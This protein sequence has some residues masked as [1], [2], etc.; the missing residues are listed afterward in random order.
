MWD[1]YLTNYDD[2]GNVRINAKKTTFGTAAAVNEH[3][4]YSENTVLDEGNESGTVVIMFN[5][6][7]DK[8][9]TWFDNITEYDESA[10]DG[11]LQLVSHDQYK[12]VLNDNL[13]FEKDTADHNGNT[14]ATLS[15]PFNQ[16]NFRTNGRY[17]VRSYARLT[18][19]QERS[20]TRSFRYR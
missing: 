15:I 9:K 13:Q 17:Y 18:A 2:E 1:Y 14:V 6:T 3:P 11:A 7:A 12:T 5:Y 16:S 8:D 19:R 4:S 10:H 20:H